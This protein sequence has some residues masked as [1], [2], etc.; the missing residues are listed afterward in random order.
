[1]K[2]IVPMILAIAALA[3]SLPAQQLPRGK[4]WTRPEVV[5][6]LGLTSEQQEKLDAIF[7]AAAPQLIDFKAEVEKA[8]VALR[9]EIDRPELDRERVER[10][11]ARINDARG[12]LFQR[13]LAMLVDMRSVLSTEQWNRFRSVLERMD[14]RQKMRP[15]RGAP[16]RPGAPQ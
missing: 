7:Q 9:G 8:A 13:E 16:R 2:R 12:R 14:G 10:A 1:M 3:T 6:R 4:W 5:Q 15:Q 11:A